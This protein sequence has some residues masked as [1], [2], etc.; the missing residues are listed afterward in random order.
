MALRSGHGTG[1]GQPHVE[2]LPPDELPQPVAAPTDELSGVTRRKGGQVADSQ[3][4]AALGRKGGLV[5][6]KRV[7]LARGLGIP[8]ALTSEAFKPLPAERQR[9]PAVP[10]LRAVEACRRRARFGPI[11][12]GG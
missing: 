11:E 9:V 7:R 10:L 12:H 8:L 4:A 1:A 6:A 5:K 3:S 2:V